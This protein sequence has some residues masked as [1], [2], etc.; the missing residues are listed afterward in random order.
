MGIIGD[1]LRLDA[2]TI[3]DTVNTASRIECLT[4][5]YCV[6]IMISEDCWRQSQSIDHPDQT[7]YTFRYLGMVQVKGKREPMGI[8]ECING[9][10]PEIMEKK[11]QTIADFNAAVQYFTAGNFTFAIT[12]IDQ[13]LKNNPQD[14]TA[15]FIRKKA[16]DYHTKGTPENW[17]GVELMTEK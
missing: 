2:A 14:K 12:A 6:N 10:D 17:N 5:H 16:I 15:L 8:Y 1:H 4:K 13:V 7:S 9:D 3:S 11:I